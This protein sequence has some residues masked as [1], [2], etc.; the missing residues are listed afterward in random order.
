MIQLLLELIMYWS[1]QYTPIY[2][3]RIICSFS[4]ISFI[5]PYRNPIY[6]CTGSRLGF[7]KW[8]IVQVEYFGLR[9]L[10]LC[11]KLK[12]QKIFFPGGKIFFFDPPPPPERGG[13]QKYGQISCLGKK[14]E[15][16]GMK[17]VRKMHSF[18]PIGQ[19]YAYFPP[20]WL[21]A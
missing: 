18:S 15:C 2:I 16:K 20:N 10:P 14:N 12:E 17:K 19:K 6:K 4:T 13:G 8:A 3:S 11:R 7:M 21:K 9:E 5:K 1:I